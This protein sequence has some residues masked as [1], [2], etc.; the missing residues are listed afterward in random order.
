MGILLYIV[1][2]S[3]S[4]CITV[5]NRNYKIEAG[6]REGAHKTPSSSSGFFGCLGVLGD[7][8]NRQ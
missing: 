4:Q 1:D 3:E 2:H 5:V 8:T 7:I 6:R